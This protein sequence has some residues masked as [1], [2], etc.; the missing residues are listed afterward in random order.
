MIFVYEFEIVITVPRELTQ[1][2][3]CCVPIPVCTRNIS[4][5][6]AASVAFIWAT[7]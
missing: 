4:E 6:Q 1:D 3:L 2:F 5:L 7:I